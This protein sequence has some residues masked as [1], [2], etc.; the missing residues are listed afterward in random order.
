MVWCFPAG[1]YES[2]ARRS[3]LRGL[4]G[5]QGELP[6]P[7]RGALPR[8]HVERHGLR[9]LRL[10]PGSGALPAGRVRP[11]G[12]SAGELRSPRRRRKCWNVFSSG[13]PGNRKLTGY[14]SVAD[15]MLAPCCDLLPHSQIHRLTV[16]IRLAP[17]VS[18]NDLM[19]YG[20]DAGFTT[21]PP[22]RFYGNLGCLSETLV[23]CFGFLSY[24]LPSIRTDIVLMS[25]TERDL[26]NHAE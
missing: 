25:V 11:P 6:V 23:S 14:R 20:G 8:R 3:V 4:R 9:V 12:V 13:H 17:Q 5:C 7:G 21:F 22:P 19:R 18:L 10:Q 2:Q 1:S 26:V 16:S 15:A 24:F